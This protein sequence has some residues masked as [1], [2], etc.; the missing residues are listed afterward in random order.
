MAT[1]AMRTPFERIITILGENRSTTTPP[2]S[3]KTA[4]GTAA[5]AS[6]APMAKASPVSF[7]TSHGW[8]MNVS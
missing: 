5:I 4:R 2:S 1:S 3:M 7:R 6:T 8:A